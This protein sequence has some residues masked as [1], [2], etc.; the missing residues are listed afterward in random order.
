MGIE[1]GSFAVVGSQVGFEVNTLVVH[2][3]PLENEVLELPCID[4][5]CMDPVGIDLMVASSLVILEEAS[6]ADLEV[7]S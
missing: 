3:N 1:V 6:L 7:A 4:L 5:D 2:A